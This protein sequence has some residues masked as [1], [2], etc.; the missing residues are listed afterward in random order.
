V[1]S[2]ALNLDLDA[3]LNAQAAGLF[4]INL[5]INVPIGAIQQIDWSPLEIMSCQTSLCTQQIISINEDTEINVMAIDTNGCM[6]SARLLLEIDNEIHIYIPNVF[7]PNGDGANDH[8]TLF[9]NEEVKEIV[10]LQIFDRWGNNVFIKENFPPN[11]PM[12]GWNGTFKEKEM[13]PAVF[14]YMATVRDSRD[15]LHHYKG[16]V[17]LV[18]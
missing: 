10:E 17:T 2:S 7:S 1:G 6:G 12:L 8:F 5:E 14:A 4:T 16:D 3:E 15:Q 13:N 18:R 11:E 9:T